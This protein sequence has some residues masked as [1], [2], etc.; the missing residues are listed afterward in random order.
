MKSPVETI[1]PHWCF[2]TSQGD[3]EKLRSFAL[4]SGIY[5]YLQPSG[6]ASIAPLEPANPE[7]I[8]AL[9]GHGLTFRF[10]PADFVQV[11]GEMNRLMIDRALELLELDEKDRVLDLFCGLGNLTLPSARHCREAVGVEGSEDLVI[12]ARENARANG[13]DNAVFHCA[14]LTLEPDEALWLS[15]PYDKILIDPPR[16]GALEM[17]PHIDASGAG[18][19]VYISCNPATL[20][21]DAGILQR[22]HG[23]ELAGAGV[24]DMFPHTAHLESVALFERKE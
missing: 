10:E 15:E 22:E 12:R 16:S 6:P 4:E 1:A 23:F 19:L 2:G 13:I 18:R 5:V 3:V 21:R 24:I 14:D 20:A 9:P 8:Y 17:L 7:L 11:N